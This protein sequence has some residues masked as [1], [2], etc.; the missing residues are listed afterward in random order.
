[1]TQKQQKIISAVLVSLAV[2]LGLQVLIYIVNLNQI[3]IYIQLCFIFWFYLSLKITV[4]YDLHFKNLVLVPNKQGIVKWFERDVKSIFLASKSR[5]AHVFHWK[6]LRNWVNYLILPGF[7]FWSTA[8]LFYINLGQT[9]L[10][11]LLAA[12][13]SVA[14][15]LNFWYLKEAFLRKEAK[16]GHDIFSVLSAIKIYALALTFGMALALMRRFC[17]SPGLFTLG[18]FSFSFLFTYQS[19]FQANLLKVKTL[20]GVGLLA[21]IQASLGYFVYMYWGLNYF[22]AAVFQIAIY[23][24]LW[25]CYHHYLEGNLTKKIFLEN[26]FLTL[27]IIVLVISNTNFKARILNAC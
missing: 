18:V 6:Y 21:L 8:G 11:Q 22:T 7:I 24:F 12:L 1:M 9:G 15:I 4:F 3:S 20:L 25:T 27:I 19:L 17:E 13:S 23:N 14:L 26:L 10:Q 5:L 16:V 2:V